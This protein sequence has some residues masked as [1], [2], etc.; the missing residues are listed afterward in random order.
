M[1][2]KKIIHLKD[3]ISSEE[4]IILIN[5]LML[6]AKFGFYEYEKLKEQKIIFN[7]KLFIMP[8]K[9]EDKSLEEI[10]DYDQVINMIKKIISDP[11]N[12]LETLAD[13]I[14]NEIFKDQRVFKVSIKIEK[15]EAIEKCKSVGYE[16]T[17]VRNF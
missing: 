6:N 14:I 15:P 4:E 7:L 5:D 12:F 9:Y 3:N 16:V 11:I 13:K 10:V 17:K 8:K 1:S 2:E